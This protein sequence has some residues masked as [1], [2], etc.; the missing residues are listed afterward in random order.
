LNFELPT[1]AH[2]GYQQGCHKT[3]I[4]KFADISLTR[5]SY[6]LYFIDIFSWSIIAIFDFKEAMIFFP[7]QRRF[8]LLF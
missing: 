2:V 1:T 5:I 8:S 6:F 7:A 3:R 4:L